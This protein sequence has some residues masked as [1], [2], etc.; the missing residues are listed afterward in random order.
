MR[1]TI[2][3]GDRVFRHTIVVAGGLARS[4]AEHDVWR[5]FDTEDGRITVVDD[6]EK[7]HRTEPL[8]AY[9][10]RR[11]RAT[12][13]APAPFIP[14]ASVTEGKETRTLHGVEAERVTVAVGNYRRDLWIGRHRA[15]PENL[16]AM[17]HLS[18]PVTS[19]LASMTRRVDEVVARLKGFPLADHAV[20]PLEKTEMVVDRTVLS[21]AERD[22]PAA[23]LQVPRGYRDVTPKVPEGKKGSR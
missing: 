1:T 16:F 20:V 23:M 9:V 8:S 15:I 7:T 11:R 13:A 6:V 19:P 12:A 17:M 14:R 22:V 4:T 2:Q 5:L 18:E 3:P 10:T 21:I